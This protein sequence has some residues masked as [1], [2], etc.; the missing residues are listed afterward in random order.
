MDIIF[1]IAGLVPIP[2]LLW[3][4]FFLRTALIA[5]GWIFFSYLA[6]HALPIVWTVGMICM[7]VLSWAF[8]F[9]LWAESKEKPGED[10]KA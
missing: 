3:K 6:T 7:D 2:Y 8:V 1:I 5:L 10:K 9:Y 4:R